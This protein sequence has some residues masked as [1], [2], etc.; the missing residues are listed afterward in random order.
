MFDEDTRLA[1]D[2]NHK[3]YEVPESM[4]YRE[5]KEGKYKERNVISNRDMANG[6]RRSIFSILTNEEKDFVKAEAK[7]I[8]IPNNMI[9]F[10]SGKQTCYDELF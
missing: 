5:W 10:S 6:N 3:R 7:G 2:E 4:T 8:N 9:Q 1:Y